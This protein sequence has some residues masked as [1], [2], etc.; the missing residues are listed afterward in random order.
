MKMATNVFASHGEDRHRCSRSKSVI[1][2]VLM[3]LLVMQAVTIYVA[4]FSPTYVVSSKS[5][6]HPTIVGENRVVTQKMA[7]RL[8]SLL[9]FLSQ[10]GIAPY[11]LPNASSNSTRKVLRK[12]NSTTNSPPLHYDPAGLT[13][14][15]GSFCDNFVEHTFQTPLAVCGG[16][17]LPEHNIKCFHNT[18][19][20]LMIY[21]I[22]ESV[23]M[24]A[25]RAVGSTAD[26]GLLTGGER[27]CP[28]IS[29]SGVHKTTETGDPNRTLLDKVA[30]KKREPVSICQQW[31]NKTAF[32][33][34]GDQPVHIYFRMNAYYNLHKAIAREGVAP[35]EFVIIRHITSGGYLF[36]EWERRKLFPEMIPID[37]LANKTIC[38]RKLVIV[39]AGFAGIIFR[40]KMESNVI[41]SCF[42]CK[43]RGLYGNSLYSFRHRVISSCGL[44]DEENH[45]GQRITVVSRTPY[46]RWRKDDLKQFQ[47]IL[48]NEDDLVASLRTR[49]PHTT[50]TVA[51]MEKLDIC[52][53][54]SLAHSAD[55]VIGVHGAGLVHFWWLQEDGLALELNPNFQAGNPSFKMLTT[56]AGRNYMSIT[57]TGSRHVVNVDIHR[58]IDALKSH[59]HIS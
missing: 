18:Q 22:L 20:K 12:P 16:T 59:K 48:G 8:S 7:D 26:I 56:L 2:T 3:V 24:S 32:L 41:R 27:S 33:Y 49:F 53:Q 17:L 29:L 1:T 50:V 51:H 39:P 31:I 36:S 58:V 35:G 47:R 42:N 5:R 54:I 52:T 21:C 46:K 11:L 34:T 38:F 14:K 13:W 23:Y 9:P 44:A 45:F 40:C 4:Y 15:K 6:L 57:V 25:P 55:V 37:E 43:G 30:A 19:S 10:S 28:S